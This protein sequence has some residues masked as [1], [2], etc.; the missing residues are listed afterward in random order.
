MGRPALDLTGVV[1]GRLTVV[2]RDFSRADKKNSYWL[3]KCNC[4]EGNELVV[5]GINIKSGNTTS[6]GCV[7]RENYEANRTMNGESKTKEYHAWVGMLKRCYDPKYKPYHKYGG[8]GITVCDEWRDD[9]FKFLED[10]GRCPDGM[11]LDR[12]DN[13][14]R[15][16]KANCAWRSIE[17]QNNNRGDYNVRVEMDGETLSV[18]QWARR[19]GF[20]QKDMSA[21]IGRIN[22]GWTPMRAFTTPINRCK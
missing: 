20:A 3:C 13:D 17:E 21:I 12:V 7:Q 15:Y 14:S 4:P 2:R 16:S 18:S 8:R 11:S 9:Y 1:S 10:M 6:C 22:R 19:Y 5:S